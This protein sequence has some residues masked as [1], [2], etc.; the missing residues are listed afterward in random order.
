MRTVRTRVLVI[1]DDPAYAQLL[2]LNLEA[3]GFRVMR[4]GDGR[5]GLAALEE[6]DPNLLILD[7]MLPDMDGYEVCRRVRESSHVP[8]IMLTAKAEERH[9][10]QGL[11]LGADDYMT[12]PFSAAELLAR[13]TSVLR[14]ARRREE[15]EAS[16][17]LTFGDLVIDFAAHRV[18]YGGQVV[19]LTATEFKLLATLAGSPGRVILH[20][21]LLHRIWGTECVGDVALL[22][23]TMGRLRRRLGEAGTD[24]F[25]RNVRGVGYMFSQSPE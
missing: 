6:F 4:V 16:P 3:S 7:V 23:T 24:G 9:K 5:A 11:L 8:I 10:V 20:D 17:R 18:T 19:P 1:E 14:R 25:I 15:P 2:R 12:K 13:I 22:R 21:E